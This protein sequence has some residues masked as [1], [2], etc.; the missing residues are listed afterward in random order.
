[1]AAVILFAFLLSPVVV[2]AEDLPRPPCGTWPEP[3][4]SDPGTPPNL[5]VWTEDDAKSVWLPPDCTG[6]TKPGF[7]ILVALAASFQF[8]G[9]S[10]D[11][12]ARFGAISSAKGIRY[13]SASDKSWRV[14]ITDA[15]ALAAPDLKR[16]RADFTIAEMAPRRFL[17]FLQDDNRS[18]G[19]V[20]YQLQVLEKGPSRLVIEV[21]NASPL[22]T[23][24]MTLF[25]PGD[26]QFLY[27][28]EG[29][30][31]GIWGI[32]SLTRAGP[33]SSWLSGGH[34]ASYASR[35]VAFYRHIAGIPTDQ[36]P[37]MVY[38]ASGDADQ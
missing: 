37:P 31:A 12:L 8:T 9:T 36:N 10:D 13:W 15:T 27:I 5:R 26:L 4:Y 20:L 11:L 22:K 1:V 32:Y 29:R 35:A 16:R 2:G 38:V 28:L 30:A 34:E 7:R 23:F 24:M 25:H 19:P 14:L 18:S 3:A 33:G 6:W 17:Y 21:E